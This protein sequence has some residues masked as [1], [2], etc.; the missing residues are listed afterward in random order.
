MDRYFGKDKSRREW[1]VS[2]LKNATPV[3]VVPFK[4]GFV[5]VTSKSYFR[6][7]RAVDKHILFAAIGEYESVNA[8][9]GWLVEDVLRIIKTFSERDIFMESVV[10]N[11]DGAIAQVARVFHSDPVIVEFTLLF[12]EKG[13][14]SGVVINSFGERRYLDGGGAV[15][16]GKSEMGELLA[17]KLREVPLS[18]EKE[19]VTLAAEVLK[20]N[21]DQREWEIG[22]LS[23]S[24]I[25]L[26]RGGK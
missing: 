14:F 1:V 9:H 18:T 2:R 20:L 23:N 7:V 16:G 13:K 15:I 11:P 22:V 21:G 25:M 17:K 6:K 19:A 10:D 12:A 26:M 3:A 8:L 4:D 24:G 5:A